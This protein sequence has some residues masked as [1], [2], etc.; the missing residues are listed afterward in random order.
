MLPN[1]HYA[2]SKVAF[3]L[4]RVCACFDAVFVHVVMRNRVVIP[5]IET[6]EPLLA[7]PQNQATFLEPRTLAQSQ[8]AVEATRAG[9]A[10]ASGV[11]RS[12][13]DRVCHCVELQGSGNIIQ[14]KDL[15][16]GS[17]PSSKKKTNRTGVLTERR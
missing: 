9:R 14:Y 8:P 6:A 16:F 2:A 1:G 12:N 3:V 15:R 17:D 4:V 10:S 11:E 7:P 13:R 5:W